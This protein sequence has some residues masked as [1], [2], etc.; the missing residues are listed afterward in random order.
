MPYFLLDHSVN[1]AMDILKASQNQCVKTFF[2]HKKFF[3]EY[4]YLDFF[5][6]SVQISQ[7][8][9]YYLVCVTV[10]PRFS[11][12]QTT[13]IY[14]WAGKTRNLTCKVRAEPMP[15]IEWLRYGRVL[16]D[17]ETFRTYVM[18]KDSN[19]QVL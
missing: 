13:L 11:P 9:S 1:L 15:T 5:F 17:N 3:E 18:A 10:R 6:V 14:N 8:F 16:K 2:K 4:F 19:L 12:N 7:L